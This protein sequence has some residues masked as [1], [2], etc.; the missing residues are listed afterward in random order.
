MSKLIENGWTWFGYNIKG[1][2]TQRWLGVVVKLNVDGKREREEKEKKTKKIEVGGTESDTSM[3]G[4]NMTIC[5]KSS[6]K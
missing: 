2:M 1:V 6:S 5:M 3:V 4:V